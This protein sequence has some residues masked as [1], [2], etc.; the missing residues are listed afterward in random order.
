MLGISLKAGKLKTGEG[1]IDS[2][3]SKKAKLVIIAADASERTKKTI[4]DKAKFYNIDCI[5]RSTSA[6]ISKAIGK[7]NRVAVSIL[8]QKLAEK[9][10]MIM[11]EV[12]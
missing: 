1:V 5:I 11:K 3:R 9:I 10:K 7:N 8:D 12:S 2:I 4:T 6:E